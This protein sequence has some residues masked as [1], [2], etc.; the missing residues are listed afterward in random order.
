MTCPLFVPIPFSPR[1]CPRPQY[2]KAY[3]SQDEY[4]HRLSVFRANLVVADQLTAQGGSVH[5][6]TKF[7]D[8]T[9]D[10]FKT[11]YTGY[12][13]SGEKSTAPVTVVS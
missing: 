13:P 1:P 2:N 9:A 4:N 12:K 8:L 5:G 3:T 11:L 10:E 6:V 7:S